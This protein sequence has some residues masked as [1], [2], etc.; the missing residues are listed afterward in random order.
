MAKLKSGRKLEIP[1][2][3]FAWIIS[4][5]IDAY[6]DSKSH[7][8]SFNYYG[9]NLKFFGTEMNGEIPE[10]FSLDDYGKLNF[11]DETVVDVGA[12][13]GDSSIYFISRG[14]SRVIAI[15][16]FPTSYALLERNISLNE[17]EDLIVPVHAAIG[18]RD[19][20]IYLDPK[21]RTTTGLGI[22]NSNGGEQVRIISIDKL[23][24]DFNVKNSILKIDCEGCEY[25]VIKRS[26]LETLT[27]FKALIIEFHNGVGD[28]CNDIKDVFNVKITLKSGKVGLITAVRKFPSVRHNSI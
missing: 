7:I 25:G 22:S 4:F 20:T 14:A 17:M 8:L 5:G 24:N 26:S 19:G 11:K 23:V 18:E 9:H 21:I 28:L 13:I 15:E 1:N 27:Q 12:N 2:S 6:Y 10:V 3:S 16:P